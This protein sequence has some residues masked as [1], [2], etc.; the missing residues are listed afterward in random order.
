MV[1]YRYQLAAF[2]YCPIF[3]HIFPRTTKENETTTRNE[4]IMKEKRSI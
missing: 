2:F 1:V 4:N 3:H